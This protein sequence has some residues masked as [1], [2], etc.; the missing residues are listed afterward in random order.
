MMVSF[1]IY[2]AVCCGLNVCWKWTKL[3][4][5]K[6]HLAV[7]LLP[8]NSVHTGKLGGRLT[9]SKSPIGEGK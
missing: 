7:R 8:Q 3:C 5:L 1:F 9:A 4:G 2:P 6:F